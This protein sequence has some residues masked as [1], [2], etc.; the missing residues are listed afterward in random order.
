M[1]GSKIPAPNYEPEI[2][3]TNVRR[4]G[5]HSHGLHRPAVSTQQQQSDAG[6]PVALE[7]WSRPES[8]KLLL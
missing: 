3:M 7:T 2:A 8:D 6:R 4:L 5:W 1:D